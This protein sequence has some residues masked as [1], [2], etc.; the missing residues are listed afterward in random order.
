MASAT[1]GGLRRGPRR[2]DEATVAVELAELRE[3]AAEAYDA[4]GGALGRGRLLDLATG[5]L[6]VAGRASP[7]RRRRRPRP[8]R[9]MLAFARDRV[10]ADSCTA[11][12]R[13]RSPT[14]R[15]SASRRPSPP[16][17]GWPE[18]AGG[19][20]ACWSP[21]ARRSPSGTAGADRWL[22]VMLDAVH[23]VGA[24]PPT[25]RRAA[26]LPFRGRGRVV[27]RR[28]RARQTVQSNDR[29]HAP[30][31]EPDAL[32]DG[33]V[34]GRSHAGA[35]G[36]RARHARAI[37]GR[38]TSSSR[39]TA[40]ATASSSVAVKLGVGGSRDRPRRLVALALRRSRS[41]ASPAP[42]RRWPAAGATSARSSGS[43]PVAAGRGRAR[44][45][46]RDPAGHGR[47]ADA[48]VQRPSG[49]LVLGPRAVARGIPGFQPRGFE[50]EGRI[51][52]LGISNMKGALVA[53]SRRCARCG[54]GVRLGTS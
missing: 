32:W 18:R 53:T 33:L 28:R 24:P 43:R 27:A 37:R 2:P 38:S 6:D 31:R 51:Y 3:T 20:G 19:G 22:G 34:E 35:V 41:R 50:R 54:R 44:E 49:H 30:G 39:S 7:R 9:A 25:V 11:T 36:A 5:G 48:D 42:R 47:R 8:L 45:R 52:G 12:P 1:C 23:D 14:A 46:A 15:S 21:A 26:A 16:A 17:P 4:G 10:E 29:L 13:R 40:P